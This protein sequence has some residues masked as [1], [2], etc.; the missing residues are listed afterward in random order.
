MAADGPGAGDDIDSALVE[1]TDRSR[2]QAA[3]TERRRHHWLTQRAREEGTFPGALVD[4]SEANRNVTLALRS[5]RTIKGRLTS[6]GEDF[7]VVSAGHHHVVPLRALVAVRDEPG[8]RGS[9][10]DRAVPDERSMADALVD[11]VP[12]GSTLA[13]Q[14]EGGHDVTGT[15]ESVGRDLIV[16]RNDDGVSTYV[17]VARLTCLNV[18]GP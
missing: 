12:I 18:A 17:A 2:R 15:A 11:L 16:V 13:A 14:L 9:I 3:V 10:G 1:L 6:I 4:L 7:V 8:T 5:G